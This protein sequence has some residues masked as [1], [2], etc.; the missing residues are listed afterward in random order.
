[1]TDTP[2]IQNT[3][4]DTISPA[5]LRI[6][7]VR[8]AFSGTTV[9]D[10]ISF[11][12][13]HPQAVALLG[14]NGAGKSTL[15]RILAGFLPAD[16]GTVQIA[17]TDLARNPEAARHHLGYLPESAPFHAGFRVSEVLHFAAEAQGLHGKAA[18]DAVDSAL[19]ECSLTQVAS[20]ICDQLSKGYRR[21]LGL[22]Q[23]LVHRPGLLMLDE[24]TDGLDPLQKDSARKLLKA[25]GKKHALL[26]STHLLEEVPLVCDRVLM[27]QH[28]RLVYDGAVPGD[29]EKL[30]FSE[31]GERRKEEGGS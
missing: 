2:A 18:Q 3:T 26:L 21:R 19:E 8:K 7:G 28:G 23:A 22:A 9:L 12:L 31:K 25:L 11:T 10:G 24:P 6:Q 16:D 30:F 20:R 27:L 5:L 13:E 29:L 1:M 15:M 4:T 14:A 17:G